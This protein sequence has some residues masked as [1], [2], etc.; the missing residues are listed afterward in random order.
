MNSRNKASNP[1][2][3]LCEMPKGIGAHRP[4]TEAQYRKMQEASQA[5]QLEQVGAILATLLPVTTT[6]LDQLQEQI[7]T[8]MQVKGFW[9][10]DQDNVG[11]KIALIHSELSEALEA[12]RNQIESDDKI[13]DFSGIE[14]ELADTV[15]RILDLAGRHDLRLGEAIIAKMHYNLTRP[16]KHGKAY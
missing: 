8:A 3:Q 7:Y 10:H 9:T 11:Q 16:Y 12:D 13:P 15:I 4:L 1:L 5:S 6:V 2:E 14:A